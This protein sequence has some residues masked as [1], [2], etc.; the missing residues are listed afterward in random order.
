MPTKLT[1]SALV[2]LTPVWTL[3][4]GMTLEW[5]NSST[6]PAQRSLWV[7][8]LTLCL[9][10]RVRAG[11]FP[12]TEIILFLISGQTQALPWSLA[13]CDQHPLLLRWQICDQHRRRWLQVINT[14]AD[15]WRLVKGEILF[16][17]HKLTG[18]LKVRMKSLHWTRLHNQSSLRH[19]VVIVENIVIV[20]NITIHNKNSLFP[21][22]LMKIFIQMALK[23]P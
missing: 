11:T 2:C 16:C 20:Q 7:S 23:I 9:Q 3:P 1:W 6:S 10:S 13:S 21:F 12:K 15:L 5:S 17:F 8:M 19:Y 22:L 14:T 18:W 4:P